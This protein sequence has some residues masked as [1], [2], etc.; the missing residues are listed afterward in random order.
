MRIV[1]KNTSIYQTYLFNFFESFISITF[2]VEVDRDLVTV[3]R[4]Y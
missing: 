1:F 2:D 4:N 3:T